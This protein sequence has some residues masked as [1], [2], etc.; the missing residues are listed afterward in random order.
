VKVTGEAI[1]K[2]DAITISDIPGVGRK[3]NTDDAQTV[4]IALES[5]NG[6]PTDIGK[7]LVFVHTSYTRLDPRITGGTI[8]EIDGIE[9]SSYW[10]MQESTGR[11]KYIA[12][13]DMNEFSI[14][15]V[16]AI[17]QAAGKWSLDEN[18]R[19][20]I[21]TVDARRVNT[22]E[23]C[24]DG[25]CVTGTEFRGLLQSAGVAPAILDGTPVVNDAPATTS[26]VTDPATTTS[27]VDAP[28]AGGT[29][30]SPDPDTIAPTIALIG[31]S[32]IDVVEGSTYTDPGAT[33]SDE[34]DGDLTISIDTVGLPIDTTTPA[35]YTVRY[36]VT[37]V[38]GNAASIS[39]S[40]TV[41][42]LMEGIPTTSTTTDDTASSS[43]L[44]GD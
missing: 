16:S 11:I 44:A 39:R 19:L 27:P 26:T 28:P 31:S 43:P 37:D 30:T 38:A 1:Q 5:W 33:A 6:S 20:V 7:V 29:T 23:F 22:E 12:P 4:G 15:N 24:I 40:V 9:D 10:Q 14:T 2:G 25:V 34:T 41:V 17:R 35:T 42:E 13:I 3:A 36:S 8:A 32:T 21:D 18:G